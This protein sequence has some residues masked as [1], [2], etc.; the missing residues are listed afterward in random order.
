MAMTH[1]HSETL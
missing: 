1:F